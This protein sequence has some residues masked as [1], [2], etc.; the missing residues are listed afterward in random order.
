MFRTS[1][2]W[3]PFAVTVFLEMSTPWEN[4]ADSSGLRVITVFPSLSFPMVMFSTL[5][6]LK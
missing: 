1:T 5:I 3:T 6:F 4:C 2:S